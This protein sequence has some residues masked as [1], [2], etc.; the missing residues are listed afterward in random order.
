MRSLWLEIFR[1]ERCRHISPS[2]YK[3]ANAHFSQLLDAQIIQESCSSYAFPII[4]RCHKLNSKAC[5]DPFPLRWTSLAGACWF[6]TLDLTRGYNQ[7]PVFEPNRL[8]TTFCIPFGLFELNCVPFGPHNA[9]STFGD[10]RHQSVLLYLDNII[11]FST[12][13][14]QHLPQLRV[15]LGHLKA[16]AL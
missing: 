14:Q 5:K 13:V 8:T 9:P 12:S 2:E 3:L 16:E 11:L 7:V 10:Q 6:S 1:S 4:L 15:V